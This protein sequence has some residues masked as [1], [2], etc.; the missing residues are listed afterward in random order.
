MKSCKGKKLTVSQTA[1][2]EPFDT[3]RP[4]RTQQIPAQSLLL[5]LKSTP[6]GMDTN[7]AD[8]GHVHAGQR[9]GDLEAADLAV[10]GA[11]LADVLEDVLVLLLVPQLLLRHHVQQTQNLRR[12]PGTRHAALQTRS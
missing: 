2:V 4:S 10:L 6:D 3:L 1:H 12:Q 7:L 9:A 8:A 11:L 5:F